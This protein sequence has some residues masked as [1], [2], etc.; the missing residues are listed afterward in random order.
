MCGTGNVYMEM[1]MCGSVYSAE[2]CVVLVVCTV[3]RCVCGSVYS[4]TEMC[5]VLVY[6]RAYSM[7]MCVW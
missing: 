5:V 1:C 6:S 2:M 4:S 3:W 7:E